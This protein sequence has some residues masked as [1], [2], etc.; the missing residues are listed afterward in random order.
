LLLRSKALEAEVH[1]RLY[2]EYPIRPPLLILKA[3]RELPAA[4]AAAT[5]AAVAKGGGSW[6][7]AA[8]ALPGGLELG[9]S[10]VNSIAWMEQQVC[11]TAFWY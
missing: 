8:A 10:A 4:T 7:K 9:G 2:T 5:A 11:G 3:L 6:L 1:V